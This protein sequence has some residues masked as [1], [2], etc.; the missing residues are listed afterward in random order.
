MAT[1]NSYR[2]LSLD[3]GGIR[4]LISALWL[5]RLEE[6]LGG[7]LRDHFD[8]IAGTST[9]AILACGAML[10][11]PAADMAQLYVERGREIFP[12]LPSRLWS[13]A[14]RT[15]TEGA[16]AP[17]YSEGGI[18]AVLRNVFGDQRVSDLP[19]G[20]LLLVPSYNTLSREAVVFK[21]NK[22]EHAPLELWEVAK[23]SAA[24]PT[25]F[26][27]H[28]LEL[29]GVR[30]PLIDG[31]VVANNPTA[32]AIAEAIAVNSTR[33]AGCK[34][35]NFVVASV[36]TGESTRPIGVDEALKWGA[37]EW[38]FPIIDVLMDGAA[39]AT[40]YIASVLIPRDRYFRLQTPLN[41][42]YDDLDRADPANINALATQ[43]QKYL[44]T[45]GNQQI[46]TL[47]GLLKAR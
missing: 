36:G 41:I 46:T 42:A 43:A 3:G 13:R 35:E 22:P 2:I 27:A 38:A 39:D 28:V 16:S 47:A 23:A 9:G 31:G 25:Y 18:K 29:G 6:E 45:D 10:G 40:H 12:A 5:T 1:G 8:L 30:A 7:R 24:A 14:T 33:P 4:G 17:K 44:E 11:M 21:S 32:C 15:F 37:L 34:L 19:Q 20:K 26:P